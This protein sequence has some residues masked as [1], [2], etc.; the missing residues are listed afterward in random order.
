M[1]NIFKRLKRVNGQSL[2]EFAVTTAMMATLA[3]TAAPKFSGVGEGAKEKKTLAD[4]DKILKAANNFYNEQVTQAGRGRFP[5]QSKYNTPVPSSDM[6][7]VSGGYTYT[8]SQGQAYAENLVK[9]A[10]D[11]ADADD[12]A[13]TSASEPT[14]NNYA[15]SDAA[16]WASVFGTTTEGGKIPSGHYVNPAED[17]RAGVDIDDPD[18]DIGQ[19]IGAEEFLDT[20]GGDPINS[21]FQDGHYIYTVIAGGGTGTQ[22][23]A[24]IIFVA[25]LESPASFYKKLQP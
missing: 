19:Y 17:V 9:L 21:P 8:E 25:D 22:S 23:V 4:I 11:G 5:G 15:S 3:T 10:L 16:N 1:K 13:G 12:D 7:G 18:Y 24:P 6:E 14:F 2:A 20:F